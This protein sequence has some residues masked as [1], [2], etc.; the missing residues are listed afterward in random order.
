MLPHRFYGVMKGDSYF[1]VQVKEDTRTGR[2]DFMPV[3]DKKPRYSSPNKNLPLCGLETT[4]R[5]S[6]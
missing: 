6:W 2:K 1:S 4:R 3:F 5:R